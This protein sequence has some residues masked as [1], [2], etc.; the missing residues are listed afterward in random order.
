MLAFLMLI[1]GAA[2]AL[3]APLCFDRVLLKDGR[4]IECTIIESPDPGYVRIKIKSVEI[5]IRADLVDKSWVE[6]LENYVPKNAQEVEY[7][8][9]GFVLFEGGWMSSKRRE[10]ELKKRADADKDYI[11]QQRKRLDWRNAVTV[12]TRHFIVKS[13]LEDSLL[14]QYTDNLEAYYKNFMEFWGITIAPGEFKGKPKVFLYRTKPDFHR[15]TGAPFNYGGYFDPVSIEL[16]LYHN[17]DN[18]GE[19]FD[20]VFHEGN[21]MLTHLLCPTFRY[22][23]WMNEGMAEYYGTA[24]IDEKGRFIVGGQQDGRIVGMRKERTDNKFRRLHDVLVTPQGEFDAFD[25]GYAWSFTH[26]LMTSP[27]YGSA[28]RGFFANLPENKDLE[29]K[30]ENI[31]GYDRAAIGQVEL[32]DVLDALERRLGKSIDELEKEWL[33]YFDQA[34][35][36]MG[37]EAYYL[38]AKLALRTERDDAEPDV[39]A[40]VAFYQ[41][42]VELGSQN[43][44]CYRDYA[45]ILR[46]GG[47]REGN[48]VTTPIKPDQELAWAV[49]Q[50]A[51]ELDPIGPYNYCEAAGILIMDGPRQD[52]DRAADFAE[53]AV[54]L[55]GPRNTVVKSLHDELMALIEPAKAKRE[56]AAEAEAQAAANDNR[57]W[58]VAFYYLKGQ[59][60]P[61]NL[62]DITTA[63]L[64]ELIRS[65]KVTDRDNVF[66]SWQEPDENGQP[67]VGPNPWDKDWVKVRDVPLFAEDLAAASPPPPAQS[68]DPATAA[69]PV[70]P[71][72]DPPPNPAPPADGE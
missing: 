44:K 4:A 51:I 6:N 63:E 45:E 50:K 21:H 22:P 32:E 15:V 53:T 36:E 68:G 25:Y 54:T 66:Q 8:K 19:S 3:A 37:P 46:K 1:L 29:I 31:Y 57:K 58:H 56:A 41:K 67:V 12:E 9:K 20:T 14:K 47:V 40:A 43:A 11:A 18:P 34:Y 24:N 39:E 23:I 35:G 42:A 71:P 55:A 60:P 64:R 16:H 2:P 27:K 48:E 62:A 52:L 59:E 7:L 65:G 10:G 72:D 33:V 70:A 49:I 17:A 38:A 28:Y 61:P 13:N 30:L 69:P 26:F 5:P